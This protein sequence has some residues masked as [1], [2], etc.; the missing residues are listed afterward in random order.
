M[1]TPYAGFSAEGWIPSRYLVFNVLPADFTGDACRTF[2]DMRPGAARTLLHALASIVS[3]KDVGTR[4]VTTDGVH[5]PYYWREGAPKTV[6]VLE[7]LVDESSPDSFRG[8]RVWAFAND[9]NLS[10]A[11]LFDGLVRKNAAAPPRAPVVKGR[12]RPPDPPIE[13]SLNSVESLAA[14]W[15][16]Y[17][18]TDAL[19]DGGLDALHLASNAVA[20]DDSPINPER[21]L[22]AE[23]A[24]RLQPSGLIAEQND[25]SFYFDAQSGT[26]AADFRGAFPSADRTHRVYTPHFL[27][28]SLAAMPLPHRI[29]TEVAPYRRR[30]TELTAE[31]D[32]AREDLDRAAGDAEAERRIRER[33]QTADRDI[34]HNEQR[35][36]QVAA[37][38]G[39]DGPPSAFCS[40]TQVEGKMKQRN[41]FM[42]LADGNRVATQ[43]IRDAN[44]VGTSAH[45]V[46]M[47]AFRESAL[48]EF[49]HA[50]TTSDDVT[51]AV[52]ESRAWFA[53]LP[54]E[55][56]WFECQ[57]IALDLSPYGNMVVRM[58]AEFEKVQKIETN[59]KLMFMVLLVQLS[60]HR[61]SFSLHPNLLITGPGSAG[62]SYVL[63]ELEKMSAPGTYI[64]VT[65]S[66][67]Q[68][69]N[70]DED[71]SDFLFMYHE[72]RREMFG[73]DKYGKD[74]EA[75]PFLKN[76]ISSQ[77]TV[78]I[79]PDRDPDSKSR[80][81]ITSVNR[82]MGS[83]IFVSNE[84]VPGAEKAM[85]MR[86]IN[87]MVQ[88]LYRVDRDS[89][90][91]VFAN[92]FTD[93][94]RNNETIRHGYKL[95]HFFLLV[96]EKA[97]EA[98]ALPDVCMDVCND[99]SRRVFAELTKAGIRMPPTR[100]LSMFKGLARTA[101]IYYAIEAA[102]FG[103]LGKSLRVDERGEPTDFHPSFL[104]RLMKFFVCSEETTV[105]VLTLMENVWVP[106]MRQAV[107]EGVA[108]LI[109][110]SVNAEGVCIVGKQD[111]IRVTSQNP[112]E[113]DYSY[114]CVEDS[115][116][117]QIARTIKHQMT[118]PLSVENILSILHEM[119]TQYIEATPRTCHP[120]PGGSVYDSTAPK[121]KIQCAIMENQSNNTRRRRLCIAV[122]C[123]GKNVSS[124]LRECV[125]RALEHGEQS[126]R[127][128]ITGLSCEV[129]RSEHNN[130]RTDTL[131]NLFDV[132]R[133]ER[134]PDKKMFVANEH[135]YSAADTVALYARG[136]DPAGDGATDFQKRL[137]WTVD[138][139][140]ELIHA[141]NYWQ[142]QGL[143]P[144]REKVGY[145]PITMAAVWHERATDPYYRERNRS[146]VRS[147]PEEWVQ[148]FLEMTDERNRMRDS[149][150]CT[151][152]YSEMWPVRPPV[153]TDWDWDCE[154]N[155]A[156]HLDSDEPRTTEQRTQKRRID[157]ILDG[158]YDG[159]APKRRKRGTDDGIPSDELDA[160]LSD[161]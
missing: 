147:Y 4:Y 47:A 98:G 18:R 112:K 49:W 45:A 63:E 34:L 14:L 20:N 38:L 17:L 39:R 154:M 71:M 103:E 61:Y 86:F 100:Q 97:I 145:P 73:M 31:R 74:V 76:R 138:K 35:V 136:S 10:F 19:V 46:A 135:A 67:P 40:G 158:D 90:G 96:V 70:S 78:T 11:R 152:C 155:G 117:K 66:T 26:T 93:D 108:S 102:F 60:S 119:E 139:P 104:Q 77:K 156:L 146:L 82:C 16:D 131:C 30:I 9:P 80:R 134:R 25:L 148:Q 3:G 132:I 56:R 101:Q 153:Q 142:K 107:I 88:E 42:R 22:T 105:H 143:D 151:S 13:S 116:D 44:E 58:A 1:E 59:F 64:N 33:M 106:T 85:M 124:V 65:H 48:S 87:F 21:V 157:R 149:G 69:F 115:N 55:K 27:P 24:L 128:Y 5:D 140:L 89:D 54:A 43:G 81:P 62:K 72:M 161:A 37:D 144:E 12:I 41:I 120:L 111:A 83:T 15:K 92:D 160:M 126:D 7:E 79:S 6:Q 75:D 23:N 53:G 110:C 130:Y 125:T 129:P 133:L 159:V 84:E 2:G 57:Q 109:R 32:T 8:F 113:Y 94:E 51:H 114:V 123:I 52:K 127:K 118:T 141:V 99:V 50:F 91:M 150:T 36:E 68:A 121:Q 29:R 28:A 137:G 95:K 122:A